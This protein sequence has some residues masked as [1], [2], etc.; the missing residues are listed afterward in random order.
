MLRGFLLAV[1]VLL[2]ACEARAQVDRAAEIDKALGWTHS[3]EYSPGRGALGILLWPDEPLL[4]NTAGSGPLNY[5]VMIGK[6]ETIDGCADVVVTISRMYDN[7][8]HQT[9]D[10][11]WEGRLCRD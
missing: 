2:S 3:A 7:Q 10:A 9:P 6:G 4:M 1:I 5:S 11:T 8:P